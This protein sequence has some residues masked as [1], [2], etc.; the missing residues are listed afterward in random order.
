MKKKFFSVIVAIIAMLALSLNVFA[1][2]SI[3]GSIDMPQASSDKGS[4]TLGK[5]PSGKYSRDLQN[6]IDRLNNAARNS[7]VK[8][9]FG[10]KLPSSVNLYDKNGVLKKNI[11]LGVYKFLSRGCKNSCVYGK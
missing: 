7:S 9:A 1:A 4:V 10:D 8:N 2:N 3:V 5:V 6:V 11:D